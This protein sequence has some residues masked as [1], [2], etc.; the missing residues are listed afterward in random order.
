MFAIRC[1]RRCHAP[2]DEHGVG[3]GAY[4]ILCVRRCGRSREVAVRAV[5]AIA[6]HQRDRRASVSI[7]PRGVSY[8]P[9][10][11]RAA[12]ASWETWWVEGEACFAAV[13]A[14]L[15][16][17]ALAGPSLLPGWDRATVIA[18]VATN[19]DAL[20]NL[21]RWAAT[22]V[23]TPMYPSP[24]ARRRAIAETASLPRDQLVARAESAR[25]ELAARIHDL[26]PEAW[27][28]T[29]ETRDGRA[30][31]AREVVWMRC[32]EVWVHA[33]DLAAGVGFESMPPALLVALADDIVAMWARRSVMA[34]CR[35]VAGEHAWGVEPPV[36]EVDL[37]T[38]VAVL[39][40]R[41]PLETL[42]PAVAGLAMPAWI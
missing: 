4:V 5:T 22:G 35:L 41:A 2:F 14:T 32:R 24:E 15:A 23:P 19:A 8:D 11:D 6:E 12:Q 37:A 13:V 40:G 1:G 26:A 36:V 28:R 38:A 39:S 33:V 17:D 34:P 3:P 29:V 42:G 10:M 18:H 16:A 9:L 31:V 7:L 21:L 30:I 27:D 20:S 25:R